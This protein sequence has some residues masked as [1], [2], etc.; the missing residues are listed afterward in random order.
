VTAGRIF[1][2][3]SKVDSPTPDLSLFSNL[4]IIP[5]PSAG[6]ATLV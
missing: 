5:S 2:N 3:G 4:R 6:Y 1:S